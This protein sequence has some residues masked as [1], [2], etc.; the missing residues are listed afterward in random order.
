M[1][2]WKNN[3]YYIFW[4]HVGILRY[5]ACSAHA[6]CRHVWPSRL[7]TV[8]STLS[9]KL[10]DFRKKKSYWTGNVFWFSLQILSETSHSNKK[11]ARY[12]KKIYIGLHVKYPLFLSDFNTFT[13]IVDLSRF[14]NLCLKSPAS[15]LVDLT[16][17]SRALRSFS[18]N[19]LRNL[20]L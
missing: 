7:Y 9:H 11:R 2:P 20:S 3:K 17:Q 8:F 19:Q 5:P 12:D 15:T 16:F 10:H 4:V 14:N 13:A 18:L 6:P 1:L